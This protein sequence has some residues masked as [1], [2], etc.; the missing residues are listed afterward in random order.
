MAERRSQVYFYTADATRDY[1]SYASI[2]DW[3]ANYSRINPSASFVRSLLLCITDYVAVLHARL[4]RRD[5]SSSSSSNAPK[6]LTYMNNKWAHDDLYR[7]IGSRWC[8]FSLNWATAAAA[9]EV[10]QKNKKNPFALGEDGRVWTEFDCVVVVHTVEQELIEY[11]WVF[12]PR[13]ERW[14]Y[15]YKVL[16]SPYIQ[17][18][19]MESPYCFFLLLF[20][21][22][23]FFDDSR[24]NLI[25]RATGWGKRNPSRM[26]WNKKYY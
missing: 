19:T 8:L 6:R 12:S 24:G 16:L 17:L 13:A 11:W 22:C 2:E 1:A 20:F 15:S 26:R 23:L 5:C 14:I 25:T 18:K 3:I 4:A 7:S 21:F 9:A 10:V